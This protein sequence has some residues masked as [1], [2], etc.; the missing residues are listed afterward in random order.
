[1]G[2]AHTTLLHHV[3]IGTVRPDTADKKFYDTSV[4]RVKR[5][6]AANRL[7]KWQNVPNL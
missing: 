1:V 3:E 2:I 5:E 6:L 4:K 7:A